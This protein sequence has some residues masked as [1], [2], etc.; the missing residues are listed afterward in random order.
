MAW[1]V[2]GGL[3]FAGVWVYFRTAKLTRAKRLTLM[4][5]M[6]LVMAMT[7]A[8]QAREAPPPTPTLVAASSLIT[9]MALV[10]FGAWIDRRTDRLG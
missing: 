8:G 10:G 6:G 2:E 4:S 5:V 9:I 1:C 7:I 3:A